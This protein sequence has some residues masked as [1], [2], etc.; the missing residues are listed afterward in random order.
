V[1][2]GECELGD[3]A[4]N[5][6]TNGIIL[7]GDG[8]VRLRGGHTNGEDPNRTG[9]PER[10]FGKLAHQTFDITEDN[11]HKIEQHLSKPQLLGE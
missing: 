7:S 8:K 9:N 2:G 1:L 4:L 6:E 5:G 10:G 11:V 3:N